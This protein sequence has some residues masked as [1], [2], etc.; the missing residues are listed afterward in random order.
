MRIPSIVKDDRA[1]NKDKRESQ[2][3]LNDIIMWA[4][5][6]NPTIVNIWR[7]LHERFVKVYAPAPIPETSTD[8]QE[9]TSLF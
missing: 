3:L 6:V 2:I 7:L 8:A 5:I 9:E 4:H 1:K